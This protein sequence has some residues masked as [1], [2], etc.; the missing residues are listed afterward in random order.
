G[1]FGEYQDRIGG[2]SSISILLPYIYRQAVD[3]D[4]SGSPVD[5]KNYPTEGKLGVHYAKGKVGILSD[6]AYKRP[7]ADGSTPAFD[8]AFVFPAN[9]DFHQS[10]PSGTLGGAYDL[11]DYRDNETV[12]LEHRGDQTSIGSGITG[13]D[14]WRYTFDLGPG[15]QVLYLNLS[16]NTGWGH[17]GPSLVDVYVDNQFKGEIK[18]PDTLGFD[19]FKIYSVGPFPVS[20]GV[21][22]IVV[23]FPDL[24]T[25]YHDPTGL[26]RIEVVRVTGIGNVT[27]QLTQD[28]FFKP[29][30]ALNVKLN[31]NVVYGS[32][33]PYA[34]EF[35][36][37]GVQVSNI[38]DGGQLDNNIISWDLAA[39]TV[40]KS[41]SYTLIPSEGV[42][43]LIFDGL[44]DVGLPLA[45]AI[46]GD[47]SVTNQL[48][49]FG[50]TVEEKKD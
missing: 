8:Q 15:D 48:W 10:N 16:I 3:Y 38:S 20:G 5:G 32:Y 37:S 19:V 42:K 24:P 30:E 40:S 4:F 22:A 17:T 12:G 50:E 35:V 34:E 26:E 9:A 46:R 31:A 7:T 2:E 47:T 1:S 41:F 44:A 33:K 49:L 45:E 29:G 6:T 23:A 13:G 27:R 18:A 21:H 28:G 14:W 11:D 39:T 36:P 43:F 25:G